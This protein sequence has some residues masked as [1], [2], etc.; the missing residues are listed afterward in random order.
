MLPSYHLRMYTVT[1]KEPH[2][3]P[4]NLSLTAEAR[5]IL[6]HNPIAT[7]CL[8]SLHDIVYFNQKAAG[9]FGLG[10][11]HTSFAFLSPLHQPDK[12][13]SAEK[14]SHK[15]SEALAKGSA[16]FDWLHK[17]IKGRLIPTDVQLY[18][19]KHGNEDCVLA[20]VENVG[21]DSL[22]ADTMTSSIYLRSILDAAPISATLWD[23]NYSIIDCNKAS[24]EL[25]GLAS[26]EEYCEKFFQLSP[27]YQPDGRLSA[28]AIAQN[29][30]QAFED[31]LLTFEWL[32]K[33]TTGE[34]MPTEVTLTLI[35]F[36][37]SWKMVSYVKDLTE[38]KA[39]IQRVKEADERT[40]IMLDATP[41]A[42]D[43][44]DE[45]LNMVDCNPETLK[46]FGLS[47][48]EEYC[49]K[50]F[51]LSPEFQ[52]NGRKSSEIAMEKVNEA[53]ETGVS[54]FE[55]LHCTISGELIP[56]EVKLVRVT[57]NN[58]YNLAGYIR[59]VRAL[60]QA[61]QA[62]VSA[63]EAAE[64]A[65][66]A[67]SQFL[68]NMSHEIRTP[69][70]AIIGMAELLRMENLSCRSRKYVD[71]ISTSSN[72]L[73]GII[74]EILDFSKIEA[75]KLQILPVSFDLH[76]LLAHLD[77]IFTHTARQS[78]LVFHL[79]MADGLP[80]C[81]YAD[82][83]RLRQ[84]LVNNI[85]NAIKFTPTGSV[86]LRASYDENYLYF[87]IED[88]GIGIKEEDIPKVFNDFEQLDSDNNRKIGGTGLGLSI[89]KNLVQIMGGA[90]W[91]ESQY[92]KGS[93]FHIKL[94]LT[95]GNE[96]DLKEKQ[97]A[98]LCLSAPRADI[99]VV[100]DN[101][102]N[103]N[104]ASGLLRSF[105]VICDTASS[106]RQALHMI[107]RKSY[108][109]IFMDHMM[110]EMDGV[111]T[112]R[113]LRQK[114]NQGGLTVI[115]LTA[116]AIAGVRES[117]LSAGM[118][119]FLSKPI[120]KHLLADLLHKWLPKEKIE[121]SSTLPV[122]QNPTACGITDTLRGKIDE[123]DVDLAL[124]RVNGMADVL[125]STLGIMCRRLPDTI[126]RLSGLLDKND[127][128][129]FAIEVHGVKGSLNNIGVTLL[130]N[131]AQQLE[132]ESKAG[133]LVFCRKHLPEML[134][135]L[136]IL[137]EQLT[138]FFNAE[139]AASPFLKG[140]V[141]ELRLQLALTKSLLD[142]FEGDQ[143]TEIIKDIMAY[144]YGKE[145]NQQ[146]VNILHSVEE[147]DFDRAVSLIDAVDGNN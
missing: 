72:A 128:K 77:S 82:D 85:G 52:P 18:R 74:N 127:G 45:N 20:Y 22:S 38:Q 19:I 94:P 83:I 34:L 125:E 90:I 6:D 87:D 41:L 73:M 9:L 147:F 23:D 76:E 97:T 135:K 106:G 95:L 47:S 4:N 42:C 81:L 67:K 124:E 50:F 35:R 16:Q 27:E 111:E 17:D 139:T 103:L 99:L 2:S 119:D 64:T 120:D 142:K 62:L 68:S 141:P 117:L 122:S 48:K 7:L 75:G 105:G 113:L 109:I 25:F 143:A 30:R 13:I 96:N 61:H 92:G 133:N 88:T 53:F 54:D 8:N 58:V 78:S 121:H 112:T 1:N 126:E 29:T 33:K 84:I 101:E 43:F 102:I 134:Q 28:T 116:N 36:N 118:D 114:N 15:I 108:D 26:V 89:T 69:M 71:D 46:L 57:R 137:Q 98:D 86:K 5:A 10:G 115:A 21:I 107:E 37:D 11:Q 44:W 3:H 136:K 140:S 146:L 91:L 60:K 39:F 123:M 132:T 104:V 12:T 79:E 80:K 14:A 66:M 56:A 49:E 59:D 145:F 93:T 130:A 100:D 131:L 138:L 129:N 32:H 70:N 110:P 55:W 31:G 40:Q 51:M 24:L 63:K 144:D 65:N